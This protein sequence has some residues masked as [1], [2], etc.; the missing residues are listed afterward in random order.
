MLRTRPALSIVAR[1]PGRAIV[2]RQT[3]HVHDLRVAEA[4][5]PGAKT[6][7]IA[8]GLRTV[9]DTPLLREGV[10]IG[11]IHIRRR[12]VRPFSDR[13]IKLLETFADQAVIAIENARLIHE[14][15]A[16]NRDLTEALEQQTATSEILRVISSSPTDLKPVF[17]TILADAVRLCESHNGAIFKF[18]GEALQLAADYN[19]TA[20][21]HAYQAFEP[22]RPGRESAVRRVALERRLVH[23]PDVLADP[24][25]VAYRSEPYRQEGMR[26]VLAVPLLKETA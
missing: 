8:V 4:E 7:G 3:I 6:S 18:D 16:R 12:E 9:L 14:Q 2:D 23:I 25:L 24:E 17:E 22:F 20:E 13:Q 5:F 21:F 19:T 10:A 11:A 15:Q 1:P 26:S